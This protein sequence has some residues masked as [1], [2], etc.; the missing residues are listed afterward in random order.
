MF[1][2]WKSSTAAYVHQH[3]DRKLFQP[4][5]DELDEDIRQLCDYFIAAL[6]ELQMIDE[7]GNEMD[8]DCDEDDVLE[9][10]LQRFLSQ[11]PCDAERDLL[12]TQLIDAFLQLV[13]EYSEDL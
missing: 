6:L 4:I 2:D 8:A 5:A 1:E 13:E 11:H 7:D 10:I 12:Y 3:I 9:A